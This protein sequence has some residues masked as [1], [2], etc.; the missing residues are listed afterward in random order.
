MKFSAFP[1]TLKSAATLILLAPVL[2]AAQSQPTLWS[3]EVSRD[4]RLTFRYRDAAAG[5][6]ELVLEGEPRPLPMER[7]ATGIWSV[8]TRPLA[9]EI[10]GYHFEADGQRRIDPANASTKANLV[11]LENLV[12]VPGDTPQPWEATNVPHGT[13]HY[14]T[15]TTASVLNLPNNQSEYYVYTPP[16]YDPRANPPWPVLYLLH[17]WSDDASGWIAVGQVHYILDNLIAEG[18]IKPMVVVMPLGYGNMDFGRTFEGWQQPA[19][20]EQNT[21]LFT[22]ALLTEVLPLVESAYNV[23]PRRED[24]AIAGLSMGGLESLTIGLNHPDRFAWV[25]GFSSAV[26]GLDMERQLAA[27]SPLTTKLRLLWL[28]CGTDEPLLKPNREFIAWLKGKNMPVTQFET[29][30]L[31]TWMVWRNDFIHFASLLFRAE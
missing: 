1:P 2:A 23:S 4:R 27:L 11:N 12:A 9:P 24:R 31:H 7:D 10:Y 5:R 30:G 29:P 13:V 15:Y 28:A 20:I 25:G 14:H 26:Q 18:K 22:Q 3:T 19:S 8:T 17:G 16:S 21:T 6:V